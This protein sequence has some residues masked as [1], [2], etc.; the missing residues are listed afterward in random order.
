MLVFENVTFCL[1]IF[2][3][4]FGKLGLPKTRLVKFRCISNFGLPS[5]FV[6]PVTFFS[7]HKSWFSGKW[8]F[9]GIWKAT[10]TIEGS[11]IFHWTMVVGRKGRYPMVNSAFPKTNSNSSNLEE[12]WSTLKIL[13]TS[14]ILNN[15]GMINPKYFILNC[16]YIPAKIP[17][18]FI[19]ANCLGDFW[20]LEANADPNVT[21]GEAKVGCLKKNESN[22]WGWAPP[23]N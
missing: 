18:N 11:A 8:C 2:F 16:F 23:W 22:W 17:K 19:K 12:S 9:P 3:C 15:L 10:P 6:G 21:G 20:R 4:F 13:N 5:C 1:S 14:D 7:H